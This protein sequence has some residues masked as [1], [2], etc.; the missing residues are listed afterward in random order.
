M[1]LEL[2]FSPGACSRVTMIALEET[3]QA[4]DTHLVAFMA[5]EHRQP[6]YLRLNPAGK[7]PVLVA[8]GEVITQNVA[9]LTFLAHAFPDAGLLPPTATP[10]KDAQL[11]GQLIAFTADLHPIVT[12]IAFP[13]LMI[14]AP[15]GPDGLRAKAM[16]TMLNQLAPYE[17]LLTGQDWLAGESWSILD[18]YLFWV[19][20]RIAGAGFDPAPFP[21]IIGHSARVSKR[22]SVQ[23]ALAREADAVKE[24]EARGLMP[25]PMAKAQ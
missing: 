1:K 8:D 25:R 9:I 20:F 24:L 13:Q 4:F 22:P 21:A 12:R 17:A 2:Y 3:G 19:W 10:L 18:A 6:A 16:E 15:G 7:V 14:D 5:G 23:R 11:L